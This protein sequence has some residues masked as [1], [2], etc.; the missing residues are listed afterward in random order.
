VTVDAP[1]ETIVAIATPAGEGGIGIVRLSGPVALPLARRVFRRQGEPLPEH[2][3]ARCVLFGEVFIP[4]TRELLDTALLTY[5]RRPR[6]YTGEDVVELS[7]H[8]SDAVLA[9]LVRALVEVGARLAAP[10]EFTRRA[11]LN[12]RLD[13]A[14]AEAVMDLIQARTGAAARL[15]SQQLQGRLSRRI[16]DLRGELIEF[17]AEVEAS[18]D[19]PDDVLAPTESRRAAVLG[20]VRAGIRELL[21]TWES[22]RLYREG[23]AIALVGRPNVGKSSLLNALLGEERAIVADLPGTTRDAIEESLSLD[24]LPARVVD[25]AGLRAEAADV[26]AMGVERARERLRTADLILWVI[27]AP[28]GLQP[29]DLAIAAALRGRAVVVAANKRDLGSCVSQAAVAEALGAAA[30][31]LEVSAL[32][33]TGLKRLKR[34]LRDALVDPRLAGAPVVVNNL[35]HYEQ[36]TQAAAALQRGAEA[37][38]ND[39]AALSA[40]VMLAADALG[41]ITGETV[42]EETISQIFARFCVGK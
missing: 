42:S 28:T 38:R 17:L 34:A 2:V 24:G 35:R 29:E 32:R 9:R 15:A 5:F 21:R 10:G 14:R 36:L 8:G 40:D 16:S 7:C 37:P 27:E 25:T 13:L 12:G 23:A 1:C 39:L 20:G 41:E 22:G 6:S 19:F 3:Q 26:E 31:V 4:E 11:F 33:G 18:I 30:V